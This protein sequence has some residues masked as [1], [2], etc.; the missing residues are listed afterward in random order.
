GGV[1]GVE[2]GLGRDA[3]DVHA[4]AAELL[5]LD[6]GDRE[7]E[8]GGADG[9]DIAA[10]SAAEDDDIVGIRHFRSPWP[11]GSRASASGSAGTARRWRRRSRGGRTTWSRAS[12][13]AA[14]WRR[15]PLPA[16]APCGPRPGCR[17][18]VD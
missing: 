18:R 3:A 15:P 5:L 13:A 7:A 9:A 17:P 14:R 2:Q 6:D 12:G 10:R 1:G 8:L 16:S 4:D 11:G